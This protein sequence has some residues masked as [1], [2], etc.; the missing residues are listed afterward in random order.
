VKEWDSTESELPSLHSWSEVKASVQARIAPRFARAEA[1]ERAGRYLVGLI[2]RV[3]RKNGGPLA[4]TL[5]EQG[6]QGVQRL[7]SAAVWDAEGVRDESL[8]DSLWMLSAMK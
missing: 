7:P 2:D 8:V 5:G 6:P 4:E 1:R 3:E